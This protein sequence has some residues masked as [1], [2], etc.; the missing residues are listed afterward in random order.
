MIWFYQSPILLKAIGK[1]HHL[2]RSQYIHRFIFLWYIKSGNIFVPL[3]KQLLLWFELV[4]RTPKWDLTL[5]IKKLHFYWR[6]VCYCNN[7]LWQIDLVLFD[8]SLHIMTKLVSFLYSYYVG[9]SKIWFSWY[10]Q[11]CFSQRIPSEIWL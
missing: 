5:F 1:H 11:N 2:Q 9:K 3:V 10:N 6:Y 8:S 4:A 7:R